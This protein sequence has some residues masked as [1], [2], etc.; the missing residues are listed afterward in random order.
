MTV[1]DNVLPLLH[2]ALSREFGGRLVAPGDADYDTLR[3]VMA[4]DVDKRPAIIARPK[5]ARDVSRAVL[6][7]RDNGIELA[8]R[9]GGHSGAGHSATEGGLVIDMREM[10]ALAID[11]DARTAWAE[12]G[13]TAGEVSA[14]VTERG[15][16][17][18][19]GDAATVGIGGITLGGGVGYLSRKHGLT[20][21][22]VLAAEI[23]TADGSIRTID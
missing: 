19:F 16:V 1:T 14:A 11:E 3:A 8:V 15:L 21:D 6:F 12:T 17:V 10:K 7:A 5:T 2:P 9:S 22:S 13:L 23:V 4:G 18:G 20:I